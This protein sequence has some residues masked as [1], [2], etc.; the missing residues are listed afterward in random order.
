MKIILLS[1]IYIELA[2]IRHDS[3]YFSCITLAN[4]HKFI[5]K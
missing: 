3:K 1:N 5:L 2:L 4:L